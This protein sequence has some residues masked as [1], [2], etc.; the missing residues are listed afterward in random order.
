MNKTVFILHFSHLLGYTQIYWHIVM[1]LSHQILNPFWFF[2]IFYQSMVKWLWTKYVLKLA[3]TIHLQNKHVFC[4]PNPNWHLFIIFGWI[5]SFLHCKFYLRLCNRFFR[6]DNFIY[7]INRG[8]DWSCIKLIC[9][10]PLCQNADQI[11]S[12]NS[13]SK[14]NIILVNDDVDSTPYRINIIDDIMHGTVLYIIR[15]AYHFSYFFTHSM[16]FCCCRSLFH[17]YFFDRLASRNSRNRSLHES[18]VVVVVV[19]HSV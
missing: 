13:N 11:K 5:I 19:F 3:T 16:S 15:S 9:S 8:F 6:V 14:K 1:R 7:S 17:F 4:T 12:Q 18:F 10:R 2:A